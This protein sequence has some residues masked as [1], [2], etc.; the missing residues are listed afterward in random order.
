MQ[1]FSNIGNICI[2]QSY[3]AQYILCYS[4][5]DAFEVFGTRCNNQSTHVD[6]T[7]THQIFAASAGKIAI[8]TVFAARKNHS[9]QVV[10]GRRSAFVSPGKQIE[11]RFRTLVFYRHHTHQFVEQQ[12]IFLGSRSLHNKSRTSI[13][14]E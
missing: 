5:C 1:F 11:V 13:V 7:G 9:N 2:V 12:R 6:S 8:R 4:R 3:F 10:F 14:L